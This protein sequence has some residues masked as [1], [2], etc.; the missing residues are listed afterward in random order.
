MRSRLSL[1]VL[2]LVGTA[3]SAQTPPAPAA[4]PLAPAAAPVLT[5]QE[6]EKADRAEG[7]RNQKVEHIH[8]EDSTNVIDEVRFGGQTQSITV[9]PK[10]KMPEYEVQPNDLSRTRPSDNRD[11]SNSTPGK[12]LWNVHKF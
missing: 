4:A 2:L 1:I 6:Q 11:G 5:P 7:R 12:S 10:N 9:Q 8:L 3:V